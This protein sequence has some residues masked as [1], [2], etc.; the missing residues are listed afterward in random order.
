[1]GYPQV[2]GQEEF[3]W[4][5]EPRRGQA[6][7]YLDEMDE[8]LIWLNGQ[9]VNFYFMPRNR[10]YPGEVITDS[11]EGGSVY[12]LGSYPYGDDRSHENY[13]SPGNWLVELEGHEGFVVYEDDYFHDCF[14]IS[15][16][17]IK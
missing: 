10:S 6:F 2:N 5:T 4:P 12:V 7:R 16:D 17:A 9:G 13:I 11:L 8:L 14:Q 1:M 3:T 15:D